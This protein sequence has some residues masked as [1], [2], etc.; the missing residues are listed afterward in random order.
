MTETDIRLLGT[1]LKIEEI[2]RIEIKKCLKNI[3]YFNLMENYKIESVICFE[4]SETE[5]GDEMHIKLKI[6]LD[7]IETEFTHQQYKE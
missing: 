7:L 5:T 6:P 1:Y 4:E 2:I 3:P